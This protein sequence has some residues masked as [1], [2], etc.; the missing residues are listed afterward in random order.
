M[1]GSDPT[2]RG[3][4][5][6]LIPPEKLSSNYDRN[7]SWL[8]NIN[9]ELIADVNKIIEEGGSFDLLSIAEALHEKEISDIADTS[10]DDYY[11]D[12]DKTPLDEEGN[13]GTFNS[14]LREFVGGSLYY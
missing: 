2:A 5:A 6:P 4:K 7:Q 10:L 9:M 3:G 13:P 14:I 8:R 11:L 1:T 12:H